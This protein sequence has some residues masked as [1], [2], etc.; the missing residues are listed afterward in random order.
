M[1]E[2]IQLPIPIEQLVESDYS[3]Q[4]DVICNAFEDMWKKGIHPSVRE[5]STFASPNHRKRILRELILTERQC[6]QYL[7]LPQSLR[8]PLIAQSPKSVEVDRTIA[9]SGAETLGQPSAS[10][11]TDSEL[12]SHIDRFAI[13]QRI[14][15][16]NFGSVFEAEDVEIRRRVAL[17]IAT[18]RHS[19]DQPFA[20]EAATTSRIKHPGVVQVLEVGQWR[21]VH[22]LVSELVEGQN[23]QEFCD[24]REVNVRTSVSIM[25]EVADAIAAAHSCAIIHRDLKPSNIM[26]EHLYGRTDDEPSAQCS[27]TRLPRVRVL[28][29]GIAKY[30]DGTM[31]TTHVGDLVGTPHYMSPEQAKGN[32]S[33]VDARSDVYSLGIILFELLAKQK[34][35]DGAAMAVMLAIRDLEAPSVRSFNPSI[36]TELD[37]IVRRCLQREPADRYQSASEFADDLRRWLN[38]QTPDAMKWTHGR[39]SVAWRMCTWMC[40]ILVVAIAIGYMALSIS[41]NS[42][43]ISKARTE[44]ASGPWN[45]ESYVRRSQLLCWIYD[46]QISGLSKWLEQYKQGNVLALSEWNEIQSRVPHSE[47][48]PWRKT[49]A[50]CCVSSNVDESTMAELASRLIGSTLPDQLEGFCTLLQHVPFSLLEHVSNIPAARIDGVSRTKVLSSITKRWSQ[51]NQLDRVLVLLK[52][53]DTSEL[54][55][56]IN[57]LDVPAEHVASWQASIKNQDENEV[58][59]PTHANDEIDRRSRWKAKLALLS[60]RLGDM[61][62]VERTLDFN[63]L[64]QARNY[65]IYWLANSDISLRP[66]LER[67]GS[68][69]DDW[70]CTGALACLLH[71]SAY[72]DSER[73]SPGEVGD[74]LPL[75]DRLELLRR[76][77]S[78]HPSASVHRLARNALLNLGDSE[79]VG[80]V[81]QAPES[82][83]IKSD[84]NWY[85]NSSGMQMSIVR[86]PT[87]YWFGNAPNDIHP[88]ATQQIESS[89][90]YSEEF[91]DEVQFTKFDSSKFPHPCAGQ[92]SYVSWLEAVAFC[93]WINCNEGRFESVSLTPTDGNTTAYREPTSGYRLPSAWEWECLVRKGTVSSFP[94][95]ELESEYFQKIGENSESIGEPCDPAS[96][97]HREWTNTFSLGNRSLQTTYQVGLDQLVIVKGGNWKSSLVPMPRHKWRLAKTNLSEVAFRLV[98]ISD[99]QLRNKHAR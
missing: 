1:N 74:A 56:I 29:F 96:L 15:K 93:D 58:L 91:V 11:T 22:F 68:Y 21:G 26:I 64:P 45:A 90:A 20:M 4:V 36:P 85:V 67:V 55:R 28:D 14:G 71:R 37:A 83:Q 12:P 77:Y 78:E 84:R 94:F 79:F 44:V 62:L 38:D 27:K 66:I 9:N 47:E 50:A 35:F 92:V 33:S 57:A 69:R 51:N 95:G 8:D 18:R 82:Q 99:L 76:F 19:T 49:F 17:K 54:L 60:Y 53:A 87:N 23:L 65:L 81:D 41:G 30:L 10:P 70:R 73:S 59:D 32:S 43:S 42:R 98:Y 46:G 34:P 61:E 2:S 97:V 89:F 6:F 40:S 39:R 24:S 25:T 80:S 88:G 5:F 86:G 52:K 16:G 31:H 13:N 63:P 72:T 3:T 48:D 7:R 75:Q